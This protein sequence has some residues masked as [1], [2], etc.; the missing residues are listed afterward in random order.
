MSSHFP[1]LNLF[2]THNKKRENR[3][4][5]S[6]KIFFYIKE[7]NFVCIR[8]ERKF[9][10]IFHFFRI[11]LFLSFDKFSGIFY[12]LQKKRKILK[13]FFFI[14]VFFVNFLNFLWWIKGIFIFGEFFRSWT[15]LNRKIINELWVNIDIFFGLTMNLIINEW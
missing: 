8:R 9:E 13:F 6:H 1:Y 14:E 12:V 4:F 2:S 15:K 10:M 3:K 11:L 7:E 5:S